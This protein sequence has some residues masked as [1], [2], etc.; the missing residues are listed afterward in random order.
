MKRAV[1]LILLVVALFGVIGCE[2]EEGKTR[3]T[4]EELLRFLGIAPKEINRCIQCLDEL[5]AP[6]VT[7]RDIAH[8]QYATYQMIQQSR[9]GLKGYVD[10]VGV[11]N[12]VQDVFWEVLKIPI[13][14]VLG[15]VIDAYGTEAIKELWDIKKALN[16]PGFG[17]A[18]ELGQLL[19]EVAQYAQDKSFLNG[20]IYTFFKLLK[21]DY[22]FDVKAFTIDHPFDEKAHKDIW[23]T[24]A[25]G[26]G[27]YLIVDVLGTAFP[28]A[29]EPAHPERFP[30]WFVKDIT[31]EAWKL[32]YAN[33]LLERDKEKLRG[34][35]IACAKKKPA[36]ASPQGLKER[37]ERRIQEW[38]R[39]QRERIEKKVQEAIKSMEE[40]LQRRA[41]RWLSE[42]LEKLEDYLSEVCMGSAALLLSTI[43]LLAKRRR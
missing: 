2:G 27:G 1:L 17:L 21:L 33:Y 25:V 9:E 12:E 13:D 31:R 20:Q 4:D 22:G 41:E 23:D 32:A 6:G 40:E 34:Q 36:I 11:L 39:Q 35:I 8:D 16:P 37:I 38:L 3:P 18:R 24:Y 5:A 28:V 14:I 42:Q 30:P 29:P 7:F 26:P 10:A 43:V 19:A 15:G